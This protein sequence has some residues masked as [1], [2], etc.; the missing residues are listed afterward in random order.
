[1]QVGA[2]SIRSYDNAATPLHL[3]IVVG[4]KTTSLWKLLG[5][6]R[7]SS[8]RNPQLSARTVSVWR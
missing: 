6:A 7:R 5:T 8:E 2:H 1:M 3:V 4:R